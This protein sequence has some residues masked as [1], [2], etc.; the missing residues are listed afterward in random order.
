VLSTGETIANPRYYRH[1]EEQIQAAHQKIHR[2]KK[3]WG[4]KCPTQA[5]RVRSAAGTV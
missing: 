2:R 4:R 5:R 3:G 1:A